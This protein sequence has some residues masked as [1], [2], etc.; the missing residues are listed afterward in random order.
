MNLRDHSRFASGNLI[1]ALDLPDAA[2]VNQRV[3]KKLLL[4]NASPTAADRKLIQNGIEEI[5]ELKLNSEEKALLD[6]S[7]KAVKEV[8]DV[9]DGMN[10]TA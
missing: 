9:L 3:A 6:A 10:A 2:L 8:M 4:E 5:I 1:A 7:A